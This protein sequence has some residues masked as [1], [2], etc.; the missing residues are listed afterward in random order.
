MLPSPM[1]ALCLGPRDQV[2]ADEEEDAPHD[3]L[4]LAVLTGRTKRI[5]NLLRKGKYRRRSKNVVPRMR[6]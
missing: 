3:E 2:G 1:R 5:K 4:H 6:G